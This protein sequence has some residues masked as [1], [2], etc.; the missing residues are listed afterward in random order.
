MNRQDDKIGGGPQITE[1]T[2]ALGNTSEVKQAKKTVSKRDEKALLKNL[3]KKIA[4]GEDLDM[5][6]IIAYENLIFNSLC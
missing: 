2:D 4:S 1:M 5:A 3:R 6:Y